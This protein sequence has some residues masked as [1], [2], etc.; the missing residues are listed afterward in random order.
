MMH[1]QSIPAE[2]GPKTAQ[3]LSGVAET[4]LIPLWARAVETQRA[5]GMIRDPYAVRILQELDYDFS[6][7]SN[8]WKSQL[9]ISVRTWLFDREV[10]LYLERHPAG[11]VVLLGSG[12]DARSFRLDNGKANWIDIDL[13][14]VIAL[15]SSFFPAMIRH[16]MIAHSVLDLS[17]LDD[18]SHDVPPLFVAEGLFMYLPEEGL[19]AL[20]TA[21][22]DRFPGATILIEALSRQRAGLTHRTDLVSKLN[23]TFVWG[24]DSG[25]E[26]ETWHRAIRFEE[27]WP[28]F[29]FARHRWRWI[30]LFRLVP[31]FR[32]GIKISKIRIVPS[33]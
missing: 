5:D 32:R 9:G 4:L 25:R 7:F 11:T 2:P 22:A 8:G 29:D 1:A 12:L 16:R 18:V 3:Q 14:D 19:R 33:E 23:A 13:P 6:R 20:M 10:A 17:W 30:R 26:L 31:R 15:R 21:I 28:Y 27:E 24:M